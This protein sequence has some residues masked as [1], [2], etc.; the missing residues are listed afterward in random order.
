M[1]KETIPGDPT[2]AFLG[3]LKDWAG[4]EGPAKHRGVWMSE[5]HTKALLVAETKATG[6]DADA[7]ATIQ[8]DIRKTFEA[9]PGPACIPSCGDERSR[10]VCRGDQA[11][12]RS[13]DLVALNRRVHTRRALSLCEL[14]V[15]DVGAAE[16]DPA[17]DRHCRRHVGRQ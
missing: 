7:Q 9:L 17:V 10:C 11:D 12:H 4:Q 5:D 2:G 3:I 6:F 14:S 13:G 16:R 1:I 15:G 8:Q